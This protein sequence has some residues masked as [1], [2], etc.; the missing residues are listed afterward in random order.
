MIQPEV[1]VQKHFHLLVEGS[2]DRESDLSQETD[3]ELTDI[4]K[5]QTD[6]GYCDGF[7]C[8]TRLGKNG[9]IN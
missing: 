3:L 8:S 1:T 2:W 6:G 9:L 7:S 4:R 5:T